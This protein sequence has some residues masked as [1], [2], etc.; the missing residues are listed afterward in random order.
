ME[1]K[2]LKEVQY[3]VKQHIKDRIILSKQECKHVDFF[4]KNARDSLHSA[5]CLLEVS[6]KHDYPG[7]ENL[8]GFLWVVNASYYAMFY[9][10]RALLEKGGIKLKG[11]LSIHAM[12]FDA[13]VYY[14]YLTGKLGKELLSSY[15]AARIDANELLGKHRAE[16]LIQDY[17]CEKRKRASLTY[18]VGEH[19]MEN[20]ARTSLKRATQFNRDI[21]RILEN[22]T[23]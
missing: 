10:A 8:N 5:R 23:L 2:R 7:Y 3:R 22:P 9:L 16:T 21:R 18:E 15:V 20:K 11:D 1:E 14:F 4:L 13:L 12:T 6:T 19:V 17:F